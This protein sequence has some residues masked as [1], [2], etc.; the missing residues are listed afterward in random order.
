M[1]SIISEM[2][3]AIR[4]SFVLLLLFSALMTI[5]PMLL[6][7]GSLSGGTSF[8]V[9]TILIYYLHRQVLFGPSG[10][11][12]GRGLRAGDVLIPKDS[13]GRFVLVSGLFALMFALPAGFVA[14]K[15]SMLSRGQFD[16]TQFFGMMVIVS[17]L[18]L[19]VLLSALGTALPAAA[20]RLS[21]SLGRAW[22]AGRK[23]GL[24][25]AGQLILFPGVTFLALLGFAYALDWVFGA[26]LTVVPASYGVETLLG[27]LFLIPS[28]M[29]VVILVRAFK[30]A[31]PVE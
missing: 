28:V 2:A 9:N 1:H 19:W 4:N 31:Y 25:V 18:L 22:R 10:L 12:V 21:F 24:R 23:T 3:K 29:T 30:A 11:F 15:W 7:S 5:L 26:R 8:I 14:Y 16:K 20:S 13:F 6:P 17:F 27:A